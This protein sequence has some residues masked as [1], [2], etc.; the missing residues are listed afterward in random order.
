MFNFHLTDVFL[1]FPFAHFDH[2]YFYMITCSAFL[3]FLLVFIYLHL[4]FTINHYQMLCHH[5][6]ILFVLDTYSS[7]NRLIL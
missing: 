7:L 5:H 2:L 1:A 3:T 6:H 4:T